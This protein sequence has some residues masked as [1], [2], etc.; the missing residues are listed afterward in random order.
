MK[1]LITGTAGFIGFHLVQRIAKDTGYQIVGLDNVNNYYDPRLKE[2]RLAELGIILDQLEAN[3]LTQ[4]K[5]LP[6]FRFIKANLEDREVIEKLFESERFD[7]VCNLAA[8]AGVRYSL[9]NPYTYIQSNV[10]GFLNLLEGARHHQVK[11][12][13][14]AS[15]SSVYGLNREMPFSP[16]DP[17]NHPVSLYAATK[18]SNELM[19]HTYSH[20]YQL[21]TTGL[22]FF[23]VYGPYGR[24]DMAYFIFTKRIKEGQPIKVFNHGQMKRDFTYIDDITEGIYRLLQK[25]PQATEKMNPGQSGPDHS[26]APFSIYNIGNNQ[27]VKLMEFIQIIEK[28]LGIEAEKQ[29]YPMQPGDVEETFADIDGLKKLVGFSPSTPLEVGLPRFIKWYESFYKTTA[30]Y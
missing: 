30:S 8:Q 15:S 28:T 22:R 24:P 9:K 16:S 21:P 3:K 11:H 25:P 23:T 12:F 27:P 29:F 1:I 7:I 10:M 17:V 19:A 2:A 18:R 5:K 14:Y 26:S 4:S 20:L 6:N 13:I